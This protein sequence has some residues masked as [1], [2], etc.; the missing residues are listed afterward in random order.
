MT[1]KEFKMIV[2]A[3]V[4]VIPGII[5]MSLGNYGV[6]IDEKMPALM[7]FLMGWL[8]GTLGAFAILSIWEK[9]SQK[10]FEK[11]LKWWNRFSND[12]A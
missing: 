11:T 3:C 7:V 9:T 10:N 2:S 5:L 6:G 4:G 8:A 1:Q 12:L